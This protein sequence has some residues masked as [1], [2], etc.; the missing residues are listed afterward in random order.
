M[1]TPQFRFGENEVDPATRQVT[2][3]GRCLRTEP[4]V[5]DVL[6]LLLRRKNGDVEKRERLFLITPRIIQ[7]A[8]AGLPV[9]GPPAS[10][11]PAVSR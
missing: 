7:S 5:F 3:A 1:N 4:K 2:H 10:S 9:A 11:L 8:A 6:V